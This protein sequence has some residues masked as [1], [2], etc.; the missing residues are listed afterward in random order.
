MSAVVPFVIRLNV[1][2][3]VAWRVFC[4]F[5][6]SVLKLIKV[7]FQN[8]CA[9]NGKCINMLLGNHPVLKMHT[10]VDIMCHAFTRS[11]VGRKLS[12]FR[13]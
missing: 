6:L 10:G 4:T 11:L 7:R 12:G 5:C 13:S 8:L 3:R 9:T 2:A 1:D